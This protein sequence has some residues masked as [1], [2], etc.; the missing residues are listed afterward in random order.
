ML[1][2]RCPLYTKSRMAFPKEKNAV[3]ANEDHLYLVQYQT[4][5]DSFNI[6]DR[7]NELRKQGNIRVVVRRDNQ[8]FNNLFFLQ[9]LV[10]FVEKSMSEYFSVKTSRVMPRKF[11]FINEIYNVVALSY[12]DK[13]KVS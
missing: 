8:L 9:K 2:S 7:S 11:E 4:R 10:S 3:K 5:R 12:C 13:F 1:H 6:L